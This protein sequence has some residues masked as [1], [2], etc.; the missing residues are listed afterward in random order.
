MSS[1]DSMSTIAI[2]DSMSSQF[3]KTDWKIAQFI[4]SNP[5]EFTT[6]PAAEIAKIIGTSD[7]SIIRFSQKIGFDGFFELRS[8]YRR[9]LEKD[10]PSFDLN[11]NQLFTDYTEIIQRTFSLIDDQDLETFTKLLTTSNHIY[12]C[13]FKQ[14]NYYSNIFADRFLLLGITI[15]PITNINT[16]RL[17]IA[18]AEENDLFIVLSMHRDQEKLLAN[19]S[20]A[21][22]RGANIIS[23]SD[24]INK[25]IEELCT[26]NF[27]I[28]ITTDLYSDYSISNNVLLLIF[29]DI[30]FH[31]VFHSNENNYAFKLAE[32]LEITKSKDDFSSIS[33]INKIKAL[34]E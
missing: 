14:S 4:K 18:N 25:K 11:N 15:K 24:Q 16:F 8:R 26:V 31:H 13:A 5:N 6:L 7:A 12:I 33:T 22:N 23:I 32:S 19:Y 34:F 27:Q 28:P 20:D 9:E 17:H 2:I 30:V 29:L 1:Y 21:K 3:T 10:S